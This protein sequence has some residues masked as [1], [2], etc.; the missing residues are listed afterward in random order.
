MQRHK[1]TKGYKKTVFL[2]SAYVPLFL[3]PS[4]GTFQRR[5][6]NSNRHFLTPVKI[7]AIP[8]ESLLTPRVVKPA[9]LIS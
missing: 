4:S 9:S 2:L 7:L 1:G 5:D 6:I 3:C 8:K